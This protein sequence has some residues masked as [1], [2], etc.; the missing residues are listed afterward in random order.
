MIFDVDYGYGFRF[1]VE[2]NMYEYLYNLEEPF[3]HNRPWVTVIF[4]KIMENEGARNYFLQRFSALLN[5]AFHTERA[6]YL[7]DSLKAQIEPEI[8]RHIELG[9]TSAFGYS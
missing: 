1:P 4:R 6:T 2:T 3:Y 5:T 8:G 7:V 9:R